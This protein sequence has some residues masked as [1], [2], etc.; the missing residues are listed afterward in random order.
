MDEINEITEDDALNEL[1]NGYDMAE[2]LLR[3][4][5]KTE[6]FLNRLE[7]KLKVI[8][9]IGSKLALLP[10][11][12]SMVRDYIRK[13]YTYVPLGTIV[14]ILS[15]L[16]YVFSPFD[17]IPDAIPGAGLIDD[18]LVITACLKLVGSDIYEYQE[19]KKSKKNDVN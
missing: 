2:E 15:A 1:E 17:L 11:F 9:K 14:A 4:T 5:D 8:P 16:I 7:D 19:W 13:V 18:T 6:E 3:D 12:I 10:I